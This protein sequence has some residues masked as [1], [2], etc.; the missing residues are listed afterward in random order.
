M[1]VYKRT[2]N[3]NTT[4]VSLKEGA[5]E[6]SHAQMDGKRHVREMFAGSTGA[7]ITYHDGRRVMLLKVDAP[8]EE[9]IVADTKSEQ[10]CTPVAG[11]KVHTLMPGAT[12]DDPFPYCRTGGSTNLG[13]RYRV[14]AAE[15][16]CT[17]CLT[18]KARTKA[19]A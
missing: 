2:E 6:M 15:L 14:V 1:K 3:G 17:T 7:R 8:E 4:F 9:A 18:Y 16:T 10:H 12:E 11:G 5:A 19:A 13:T